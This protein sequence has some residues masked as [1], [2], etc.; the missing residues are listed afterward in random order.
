MSQ[1]LGREEE[2][3]VGKRRVLIQEEEKFLEDGN[4]LTVL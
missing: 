4:A 2:L 3:A 1:G